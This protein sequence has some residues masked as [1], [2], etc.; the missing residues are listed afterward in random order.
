ME[1]QGSLLVPQ[2]CLMLK[3]FVLVRVMD[4]L[5]VMEEKGSSLVPQC[6][7]MMKDF[8]LIPLKDKPGSLVR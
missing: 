1:E 8:V 6:C 2:C 5:S 3:D 7:L 4:T